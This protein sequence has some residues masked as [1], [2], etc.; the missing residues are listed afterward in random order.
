MCLFLLGSN[1]RFMGHM[2]GLVL[3]VIGPIK[4]EVLGS[5]RQATVMFSWSVRPKGNLMVCVE[6]RN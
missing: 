4:G 2:V 1:A 5:A 3:G 6:A